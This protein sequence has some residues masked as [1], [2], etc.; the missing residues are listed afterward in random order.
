MPEGEVD[1]FYQRELGK[2]QKGEL[3][4]LLDVASFDGRWAQVRGGGGYVQ[5]LDTGENREIDWGQW[6]LAEKIG[7]S[8]QNLNAL[9]SGNLSQAELAR[10]HYR[11]EQQEQPDLRQ[12]VKVF[13]KFISKKHD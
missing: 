2:M 3:P 11:P 7:V 9:Q 5:F 10:V 12:E 13:G 1:E 6:E 4:G 8:I